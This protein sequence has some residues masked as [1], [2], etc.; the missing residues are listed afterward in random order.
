[1]LRH[2][3]VFILSCYRSG[4][5]L[6]R[7][8][9]DSHPEVYCPP[10]LS[11]GQAAE[12]LGHF[13]A[14]L[15][16]RRFDGAR[17][18]E[19]PAALLDRVRSALS[20]AAQEALERRGKSRFCE[21]SPGNVLFLPLLETLF[22]EARF[23]CLHR[24]AK[25]VV[26]ST[27]KMHAGIPELARYVYDARGDL[28][29]A[30]VTYWTEWTTILLEHERASP[31]RCFHLR[32]ED[33]VEDPGGR[34][35][36]VFAFLGLG[37]E[38]ALLEAVFERPHDA[39]REDP[40]I[41]FSTGIHASSVGAGQGLSLL[42]VR[43]DLRERMESL[44][45]ELSYPDRGGGR[46]AEAVG[47]TGSCEWLLGVHLPRQIRLHPDVV[48]SVNSVFRLVVTDGEPRDW[49]VDLRAGRAGVAPGGAG[50]DCTVQASAADLLGIARGRLNPRKAFE[51]GRLGIQGNFDLQ[52]LPGL[53]RL[54]YLA[55]E[56]ET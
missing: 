54:L 25:D 8:V 36:E 41:R 11:L 40:Y 21:K 12:S 29:T 10:E 30:F 18:F 50:A 2:P 4:S 56:A 16:G 31:E 20:T 13:Y 42:H 27:I 15:D 55:P 17:P 28:V 52:A 34:A 9:L 38:P 35:A 32:Y 6:L 48:E 22:P 39:G 1:M 45:R 47:D 23:L 7:Y 51:D 19:V 46:A 26:A 49:L 53:V 37:W 24:H 33:L 14:G 44:L 3:P 5:T 43:M